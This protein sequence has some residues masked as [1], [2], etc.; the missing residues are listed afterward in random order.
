MKPLDKA[1]ELAGGVTKLAE[2]LG[3]GQSVVSNWR[4]RGTVI[5]PKNCTAI[6]RLTAGQVSRIELRPADWWEIWP[7]LMPVTDLYPS[8]RADQDA[9]S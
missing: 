4:A 8:T 5:D 3:Q 7:E 1:I 9:R 6:E 2:A